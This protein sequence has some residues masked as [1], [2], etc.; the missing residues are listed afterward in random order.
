MNKIHYCPI[1]EPQ[2]IFGIYTTGAGMEVTGPGESYPHDYHSSDYYF[3]WEHGR[4]LV[5]WEYQILY[6]RAGKGTIEFS[7]GKPL[8][9]KAGS[10]VILRP[11]EWH[12]YRPDPKTGWSEAY[13]GIGGEML[14]RIF[15]EPFF[16]PR[17]T[18]L[19]VPIKGLFEETFL[20]LV[21]LVQSSNTDHPYSVATRVL[22]LIALLIEKT[23]ML[24]NRSTTYAAI[25]RAHLYIAHHLNEEIDFA[26]L[27]HEIGLGHS[28]F[29]KRFFE[30]TKMPPLKF[31]LALRIRRAANLLT[32]SNTPIAQIA[33]DLGFT[34]PAYFS[35][36]FRKETGLSPIRYRERAFLS[37]RLT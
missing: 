33:K 19:S 26:A 18:M 4:K 2:K 24:D 17:E 20:E 36:F 32:S 5:N 9:L 14:G 34:T 16:T 21:N 23:H 8:P 28:L 6:I 12:R 31:Q 29:R 1:G 25:R 10:I 22:T 35:R 15:S 37:L 27:A 7:R 3:T 30:Y 11:G 13:I